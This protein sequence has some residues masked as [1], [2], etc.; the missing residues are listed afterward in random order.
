[1][2]E[3]P[4]V[5]CKVSKSSQTQT[6]M[7]GIFIYIHHT[8]Q[9]NV[10]KLHGWYGKSLLLVGRSNFSAWIVGPQTWAKP[11]WSS[12][13]LVVFSGLFS[14]Q[15]NGRGNF[16]GKK[17]VGVDQNKGSWEG[18]NRRSIANQSRPQRWQSRRDFALSNVMCTENKS[19]IFIYIEIY[20]SHKLVHPADPCLAKPWRNGQETWAG[21]GPV[22]T[23]GGSSIAA[24]SRINRGFLDHIETMS[25]ERLT[26]WL[27]NV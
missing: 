23:F 2:F 18:Y 8:H 4:M 10:G 7:Y 26:C 3:L 13:L 21:N 19:T 20:T 14:T 12:T 9:P 22:T 1:M 16:W 25:T 27:F 11:L 17:Q 15:E 24:Q 5:S 6:S